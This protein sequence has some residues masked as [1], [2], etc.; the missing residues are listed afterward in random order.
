MDP[1]DNIEGWALL[2]DGSSDCLY[3][4]IENIDWII[5]RDRSFNTGSDRW[6]SASRVVRDAWLPLLD[7]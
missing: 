1:P 7:R 5:S 3:A 6:V 2:S 4:V